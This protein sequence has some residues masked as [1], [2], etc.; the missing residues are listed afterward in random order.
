MTLIIFSI[1]SMVLSLSYAGSYGDTNTPQTVHVFEIAKI[2]RLMILYYNPFTRPAVNTTG[3]ELGST[4]FIPST[5][6]DSVPE[7]LKVGDTVRNANII[8]IKFNN[9]VWPTVCQ[10]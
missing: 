5:L 4:T 2:Q 6:K 10:L 7:V 1:D 9:K 8:R 3:S